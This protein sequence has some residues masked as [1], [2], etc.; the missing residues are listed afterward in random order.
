MPQHEAEVAKAI[1]KNQMP[2]IHEFCQA[3]QKVIEVEGKANQ[4]HLSK[5]AGHQ[6]NDGPCQAMAY[7]KVASIVFA[8]HI[9]ISKSRETVDLAA[10]IFE[11]QLQEDMERIVKMA[12]EIMP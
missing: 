9:S 4:A 12:K 5:L 6:L 10:A 8:A 7:M 2:H 1:I 11:A 3:L